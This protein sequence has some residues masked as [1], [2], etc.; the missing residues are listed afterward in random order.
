MKAQHYDLIV[1]GGGPAGMAAAVSAKE[2][3]LEKIMLLDR[4]QAMGGILPQCVH[5]GF[6]LYLYQQSLTG[7]EYA[8]MW[9]D[10]IAK[11]GI[12]VQTGST[13]L[14]VSYQKPF[15]VKYLNT[16][17][18]LQ[19]ATADS[20]IFAMGCRERPLGKMRIPGSRPAGIY[21]AG[22][23]QYMMNVQNIL[24][25]KRV[26]ILGSGDIGLIMARRLTLEGAEVKLIL[27]QK[28]SGL[29]RNHVQCVQ[30][31][32]L[33]ILFEHT[34]VST[35]GY[36]RLKG[37]TIAPVNADSEPDLSQK[38]YIHCDT[39]LVATGLIPEIELWR[40]S[41][42]SLNDVGG[43]STQADSATD[44]PGIFACGNV[45]KVYDVVDMVTKAG[46]QSGRAAAKWVLKDKRPGFTM[47]AKALPVLEITEP[48]YESNAI[49]HSDEIVCVLCPSGCCMQWRND[50][51]GLEIHGH[52]CKNGLAYA[53]KEIMQ[54]ERTLTTTIKVVNGTKSLVAVKSARPLP[55]AK[56]PAAMQ[57]VRK[58]V[59]TAPLNRGD[60]VVAD[61]CG[62]GVSLI[63][64][65]DVAAIR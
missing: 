12:T 63:A 15:T 65:C 38:R 21:T 3:G 22:S 6:G 1:I 30:D 54:P 25:G 34:L 29:L 37:V 32:N 48:K 64:T 39:L 31:F 26:V 50:D 33:P 20:I 2:H 60:V 40:N 24:P 7:P 36:Q 17:T 43:I 53:E 4:N 51:G 59:A 41:N 49:L 27:G 42:I 46:L 45:T 16:Q 61:V 5:D 57:T 13:V 23:A 14:N 62:T 56:L 55:K 52:S 35:H 19:V 58:T 10:R 47:P 8:L 28:A 11:A 44:I 18:G 9:L